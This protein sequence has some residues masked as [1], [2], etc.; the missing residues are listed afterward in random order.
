MESQSACCHW[1]LGSQGTCAS[2]LCGLPPGLWQPAVP[3]LPPGLCQSTCPRCR[4]GFGKSRCV[5][6]THF[7]KPR[8]FC[9]PTLGTATQILAALSACAAAQTWAAVCKRAFTAS[10]P[11]WGPILCLRQPPDQ[12]VRAIRS[13]DLNCCMRSQFTKTQCLK[14]ALKL[15]CNPGQ[16]KLGQEFAR[17]AFFL[18]QIQIQCKSTSS[19]KITRC[20]GSNLLHPNFVNFIDRQSRCRLFLFSSH[21]ACR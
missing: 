20:G 4:T 3:A 6:P 2:R 21:H 18:Q 17:C 8:L 13:M 9:Q 16:L 1:T 7:A 19:E 10:R 5:L 14:S 15:A 12:N 11:R